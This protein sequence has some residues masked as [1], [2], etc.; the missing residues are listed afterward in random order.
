MGFGAWSLRAL[1]GYTGGFRVG[2]RWVMQWCRASAFKNLC[3]ALV[4][5]GSRLEG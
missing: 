4:L 2:S 3:R 5:W 1:V